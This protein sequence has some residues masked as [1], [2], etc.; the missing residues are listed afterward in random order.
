[1]SAGVALWFCFS[2]CLWCCKLVANYDILSEKWL[3]RR[4]QIQPV[5]KISGFG[6]PIFCLFCQW[7]FPAAVKAHSQHQYCIFS[8]EKGAA[9]GGKKR[10]SSPWLT[11]SD[12]F[13]LRS[14]FKC[15]EVTGNDWQT[16]CSRSLSLQ[17]TR[18]FQH[19][20]TSMKGGKK[21]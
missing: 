20:Q 5:T 6:A 12:R 3:L 18:L 15:V 8:W 16:S 17:W 9:V 7:D 13:I 11:V 1:M 14:E 19:L 10:T 4:Y 21:K 2:R